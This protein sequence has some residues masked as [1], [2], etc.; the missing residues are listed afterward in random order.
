M[1]MPF[2]WPVRVYYEDTDVA[3]VVYYAN[4][5]KFYERARTEWLRAQGF[6][7]D[8]LRDAYG[9]VFVV[10]KVQVDYI[11]A[12]RFNDVLQVSCHLQK[13]SVAA[14]YFE[15]KVLRTS[16]GALLSEAKV[17]IVCVDAARFKPKAI[18]S[19]MAFL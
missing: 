13:Q 8:Q 9:I 1:T 19:A 16:D 4:Y 15:Q 6:E 11:R 3:G 18:P 17:Q 5:L 7:Q 12:A 14:L 10:S 2:F